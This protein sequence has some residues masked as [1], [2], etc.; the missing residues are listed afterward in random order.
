LAAAVECEADGNMPVRPED[1]RARLDAIE[2]QM[3]LS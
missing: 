2:R 3:S 1:V